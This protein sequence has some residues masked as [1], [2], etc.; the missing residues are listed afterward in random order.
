MTHESAM[1]FQGTQLSRSYKVTHEKLTFSAPTEQECWQAAL[2]YFTC[3]FFPQKQLSTVW[4]SKKEIQVQKEGK[5]TFRVEAALTDW[6]GSID[7]Q[8]VCRS[9][10]P[11]AVAW[12]LSQIFLAK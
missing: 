8:V 7:Q 6:E 10:C 11:Y 2:R 1:T 12:H 9:Y 4:V 3:H 5:H